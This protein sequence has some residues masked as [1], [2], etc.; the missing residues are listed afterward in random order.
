MEDGFFMRD[1]WPGHYAYLAQQWVS[2]FPE[3]LVELMRC[4]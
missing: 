4:D 2:P 1:M 3:P